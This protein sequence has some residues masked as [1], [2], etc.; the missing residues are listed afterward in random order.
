MTGTGMMVI[1]IKDFY[2]DDY[3]TLFKVNSLETQGVFMHAKDNSEAEW[4]NDWSCSI[5][6]TVGYNGKD[7]AMF[8][9]FFNAYPHFTGFWC[10]NDATI[11]R[12][13]ICESLI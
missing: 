2:Q 3:Y 13:F 12:H 10:S 1:Q 7:Y 5:D 6:R 9:I 8:G 11:V 4:I